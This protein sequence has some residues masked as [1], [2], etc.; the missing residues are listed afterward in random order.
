M[1]VA[2]GQG[3]PAKPGLDYGQLSSNVA[4]MVLQRRALSKNFGK[5]RATRCRPWLALIG[6]P[7]R[8]LGALV[9]RLGQIRKSHNGLAPIRS[10]QDPDSRSCDRFYLLTT[11]AGKTFSLLKFFE[12]CPA[13][14]SHEVSPGI[15]F[16][17]HERVQKT[18]ISQNRMRRP[19]CGLLIWR[20][21]FSSPSSKLSLGRLL[22]SRACVCFTGRDKH[23]SQLQSRAN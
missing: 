2:H 17:R 23:N 21:L 12:P 3:D 19:F 6:Q 1:E 18:F 9:F 11:P 8:R 15:G 20:R 10:D 13:S 14:P 22:L 4:R 7:F 5:R 16:L